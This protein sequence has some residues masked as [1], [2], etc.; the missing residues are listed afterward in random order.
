MFIGRT[1]AEDETAV[2]WPLDAKNRLLGKD[3]DAGQDWRQEEKGTTGDEMVG[4]HHWLDGHEFE[5][6]P[7][8]GDGQGNL[9][10]CSPRGC[11]VRQDWVTELNPFHQFDFS[12]YISV[13]PSFFY[14]Y[15]NQF[16]DEL[17]LH[18]G[19]YFSISL[20]VLFRL[21]YWLFWGRFLK[22]EFIFWYIHFLLNLFIF[23]W[24]NDEY[25]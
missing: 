12:Y 25:F 16:S 1:D 15:K 4:W 10:C 23:K 18:Y 9:A 24:N 6:A 2:L 20:L 11:R 22:F 7:G 5:Q 3:P 8:V 21:F 17:P 19:F 13:S 14:F